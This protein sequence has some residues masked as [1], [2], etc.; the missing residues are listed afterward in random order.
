MKRQSKF[1]PITSDNDTVAI[2]ARAW[3]FRPRHPGRRRRHPPWLP[4][5]LGKY[6]RRGGGAIDL[7]ERPAMT[8]AEQW[9]EGPGA[10]SVR[11]SAFASDKWRGALDYFRTIPWGDESQ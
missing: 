2:A 9:D 4:W 7:A 8:Q 3:N 6:P 5:S 11:A 1:N 10:A